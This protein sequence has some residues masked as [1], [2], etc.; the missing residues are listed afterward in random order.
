MATFHEIPVDGTTP[1]RRARQG[2]PG[3]RPRALLDRSPTAD[4]AGADRRDAATAIL[5]A[6]RKLSEQGLRVLAFAVPPL[7]ARHRRSRPTRWPR[8]RTSTLVGLVG[9]ID[10]LRPSSKEAV[11]IAREAGIEVRMITGDHAITAA[12]IGAKLGLGDRSR[13]RRRDPGDERRRAEGGASR[14]ARVRP[15]HARGQAAPRPAHAGG[16]R[17]RRDDR[18]RRE[19]RRRAQAGRHRRRD[20]VGQR[21]HEAGRQ[22]DPRRRQLRHPRH[23]GQARPGDL[24]EDRQLRPLPD[25]AAVLA[26]AALPRREHL[27]HQQR[28]AAARRS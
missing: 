25:V 23:R 22:D 5:E 3:C 13:E 1:P 15:R 17:R 27:R 24:R 6:N 8:S 10:P 11:R 28:R 12:A 18:R 7:R 20:G 21:G 26:G 2:R 19:R 9:I 14:P 4:G 16:R